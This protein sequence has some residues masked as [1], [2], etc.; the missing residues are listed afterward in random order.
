[1]AVSVG[2]NDAVVSS[3][4]LDPK[5]LVELYPASN[6]VDGVDGTLCSTAFGW[7]NYLSLNLKYPTIVDRVE[8]FNRDD[9][10]EWAAALPPFNIY[11][12]DAYGAK[13][14]QCGDTV[15]KALP[16][17]LTVFCGGAAG[18]HVTLV[19]V[20]DSPRFLRMDQMTV[21]TPAP[22]AIETGSGEAGSGEAESGEA[23]SVEAR[24][25]E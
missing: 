17:P 18:T 21:Y 4:F 3:K 15:T 2:A 7:G 20:G 11:V 22:P 6:A 1:M 9:R 19:Q 12:G 23:G 13:T 8:V 10:A 25:G 14:I 5:T 24:S 16:N